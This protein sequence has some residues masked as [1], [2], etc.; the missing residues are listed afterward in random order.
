[1]SNRNC[2]NCYFF[3]D[4]GEGYVEGDCHRYPQTYRKSEYGWCGEWKSITD[5]KMERWKYLVDIPW[6]KRTPENQKE[7]DELSCWFA[8]CEL[9]LVPPPTPK[10]NPS[11]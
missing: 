10:D 2:K 9:V 5:C 7:L 6:D 1:M 3:S 8:D 4:Y 11:C